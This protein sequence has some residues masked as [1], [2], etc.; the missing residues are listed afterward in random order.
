MLNWESDH[1]HLH[2]WTFVDEMEKMSIEVEEDSLENQ[3][4]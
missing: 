2:C 1:D 4:M 3:K